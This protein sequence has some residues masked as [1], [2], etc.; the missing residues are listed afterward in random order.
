MKPTYV[1]ETLQGHSVVSHSSMLD[2]K[3][4][5]FAFFS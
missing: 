3:A 2:M 4:K 5:N 1:L